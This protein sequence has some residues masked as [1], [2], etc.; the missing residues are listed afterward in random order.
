MTR[1]GG[2]PAERVAVVGMA[3]HYPDAR[4]PERLWEN[5]VAGR[6]AFR[7]IP[8]ERL[9]IEDY[10]AATAGDADS[11]ACTEAAL[12]HDWEFD[13]VGFR[14]AGGSFRAADLTHW[15]ALD[16]AS[17]ALADAG[18]PGAE[19]LPKDGTGVL[20]GNSLTGEFSRA[21]ILRLRWPYVRRTLGAALAEEG[22]SPERTGELLD[23]IEGRY[24]EPFD[25][26]GEETLAGGLANTIAGRICNHFDLGGGGYTVDGACASSLLAIANACSA[27]VAGD[28][29]VALAGGVDL[30][31]DPFELV[32]FSRTGA[33]SSGEMRVFDRHSQGFLPGEG[34]GVVVLMRLD[35]A[36]ARGCRVL[37][38][39]AGWGISSDGGGG[40]TRPESDGQLRA[41]TRAYERAGFGPDEIA[42][43]EAHGTGTPVG[44]AAELAAL[45]RLR[46]SAGARSPAA[47]G[48]IKALIGHTKAAAGVA[49]TIKTIQALR[50]E[51]L[52]P[53]FGCETPH[54]ILVEGLGG[55]GPPALRVV[56]RAEPWPEGHTRR[57]GVSA[58]GFGGINSHLVLEA[59]VPRSARAGRQAEPARLGP[60]ERL[61]DRSPQEAEL[62]VLSAGDAPDLAERARTLADE[63]EGL[64]RAELTDLAGELSEADSERP[65]RCAVVARNPG[66]AARRL[67]RAAARLSGEGPG[68]R[69]GGDSSPGLDPGLDPSKGVLVGRAAPR[70]RIGFL[71]PGQGAPLH[72]GGGAWTRRFEEAEEVYRRAAAIAPARDEGGDTSTAIAQP[73]I[74]KGSL[75]GLALLERL[76][77]E[78][79]VAIG[80][81]LGE[82]AAL[83]WAGSLSDRELVRIAD[84]RGRVMEESAPPGAMI[85]LRCAVTEVERLLDGVAGGG[86][87]AINGSEEVVVSGPPEAVDTI[88]ERARRER[89]PVVRLRVSRAFHSPSME[90]ALPGLGRAL[91][92]ILTPASRRSF[93]PA[94]G[95]S[96]VSTVTGA[97][98]EPGHDLSELLLEQLTRPVRFSQALAGSEDVAGPVDLWLEVGPGRILSRL[99]AQCDAAPAIPLDAGGPGTAGLLTAAGALFCLGAPV[100]PDALFRDRFLR[101]VRRDRRLLRNPCERAPSPGAAA[102][103]R[104]ARPEQPAA[105]A[106]IPDPGP[107]RTPARPDPEASD[108]VG[109][110]RHLVSSQT[111]LPVESLAEGDR[112]LSDLHLNSIAVGQLVVEA[113]RRMGAAPPADP[114]DYADASVAEIAASLR[115]LV[116]AND[117]AGA[118]PGE[119]QGP[120]PG[121]E[122]WVRPFS[123]ELVGRELR[124]LPDSRDSSGSNLPGAFT[125]I[126][127][128]DVPA[129]ER[130]RETLGADSGSGS[131]AAGVVVWLPEDPAWPTDRRAVTRLLDGARTALAE[132]TTPFVLVVPVAAGDRRATDRRGVGAA[133][134]RCLHLERRRGSVTVVQVPSGHR[135]AAAW[136]AAEIRNAG[137]GYSEAVYDATGRRRVPVLRLVER[138]GGPE[139]AEGE[140]TAG[141]TT[142]PLGSEDVLLVSGGGR[143]IAAECALALARATGASLALIGRSLPDESPELAANLERLATAGIRFQYRPADVTD[144]EEVAAAVADLSRE[145]GSVT[146]LL[147]GAG[148]NEPRLIPALDPERM[149]A[150]RR[151]KVDGLARLLEAV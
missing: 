51:I 42:L 147:H 22:W 132:R 47:I 41:L 67:R 101:P 6:K 121:V 116:E 30:S 61:L 123:V 38:V 55:D 56:P 90:R 117:G 7:R 35:E 91:D 103:S 86:I 143:G 2:S 149:A 129:V 126:A 15:L 77:V 98:L 66:E 13:R 19:G 25:P 54:P 81:S 134:A 83:H 23:R 138:H 115:R 43:F 84:A 127:P 29:D 46:R 59:A 50:H 102:P 80:H 69:A 131:G 32:G 110:V 21:Q 31:L 37:A 57:A 105:S 137:D 68:S 26:P 88:A 34:S 39:V 8:P 135:D 140:R 10:D 97:L 12:L 82:L 20:V 124:E 139:T 93:R 3:C 92:E 18:F 100:S 99:A 76:G 119:P 136:V 148:I 111:E 74:V 125:L 122:S 141:E 120:P 53:T 78:A 65:V 106:E 95:R 27:L 73:E 28:L 14:V 62:L 71:F 130:L 5:V 112:M 72:R 63:A 36:L 85:S 94:A 45:S 60:I 142:L 33:L 79:S 133:F 9:R 87:A 1:T 58:M 44:D 151:P 17:R 96:V 118:R 113:A 16:V 114:T 52:P 70:P 4:S 107:G 150:T 89:I 144:P 75:A 145:L 24:K 40:L 146:A 49:G 128:E 108:P 11:I 104:S 48:S 64:S 109:I